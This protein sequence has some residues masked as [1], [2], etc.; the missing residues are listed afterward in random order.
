MNNTDRMIKKVTE[1]FESGGKMLCLTHDLTFKTFFSTNPDL[2]ESFLE[3]VFSDEDE[4]EKYKVKVTEF[5]N[6]VMH[7]DRLSRDVKNVG[8]TCVLDLAFKIEKTHKKSGKKTDHF[9]NMESQRSV[10]PNLSKRARFYHAQL[11]CSELRRG[12]DYSKMMP[13][14][15]LIVSSVKQKDYRPLKDCKHI[16]TTRKWKKPYTDFDEGNGY[17]VVELC[18]ANQHVDQI[19]TMFDAWCCFLGQELTLELCIFF[20]KKGGVMA[21]AVEVLHGLSYDQQVKDIRDNWDLYTEAFEARATMRITAQARED[22]KEQVKKQVKEQVKK[23]V[24]EQVQKQVKEQVAAKTQQLKGELT[25]PI[26]E[27]IRRRICKAYV[28][29]WLNSC[30]CMSSDRDG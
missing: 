13:G 8:K 22:V 1:F 2:S 11:S 15:V 23:Q 7:T 3:S 30:P 19:E 29:D 24:K 28:G 18:K 21:K 26:D 25:Q 14:Y 12:D 5:L 10:D 27:A 6:S 16:F 9:V 20:L 17:I 4:D